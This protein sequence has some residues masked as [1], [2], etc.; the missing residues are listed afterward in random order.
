M[1]IIFCES[2]K[3]ELDNGGKWQDIRTALLKDK[4]R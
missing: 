1:K 2:T 4:I 3:R